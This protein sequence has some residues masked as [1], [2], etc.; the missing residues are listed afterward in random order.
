MFRVVRNVGHYPDRF[1]GALQSRGEQHDAGQAG[2]HDRQVMA[3]PGLTVCIGEQAKERLMNVAGQ[4]VLHL[5]HLQGDGQ[6]GFLAF[7]NFR[8]QDRRSH[9]VADAKVVFQVSFIALA[10][11][12]LAA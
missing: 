8:L 3:S 6:C 7:A 5:R 11:I 9:R 1:A 4:Q 12:E 10:N 2:I